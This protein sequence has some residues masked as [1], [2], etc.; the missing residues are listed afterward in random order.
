MICEDGLIKPNAKLVE[1]AEHYALD[2]VCPYTMV[3]TTIYERNMVKTIKRTFIDG[4][5]YG[6]DS[7]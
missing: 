6:K 5:N 7:R 2:Y 1:A 4:A 3:A